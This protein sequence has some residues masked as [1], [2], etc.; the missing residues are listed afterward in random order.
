MSTGT[1][2]ETC[3]LTQ[4]TKRSLCFEL[5]RPFANV[6][7]TARIV[8]RKVTCRSGRKYA[9]SSQEQT[10]TASAMTNQGRRVQK[11]LSAEAHSKYGVGSRCLSRNRSDLEQNRTP[12]SRRAEQVKSQKQ[13]SVMSSPA[14]CCAFVELIEVRAEMFRRSTFCSWQ[15]SGCKDASEATAFDRHGTNN[16]SSPSMAMIHCCL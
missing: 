10:R 5:D 12:R 1:G 14:M 16:S 11:C 7:A 8:P 2:S 4:Q 13:E 3:L 9:R 15:T 6:K